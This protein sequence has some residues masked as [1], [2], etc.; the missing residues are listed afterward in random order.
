MLP[1]HLIPLGKLIVESKQQIRMNDIV[2]QFQ[3]RKYDHLEC[4]V[5][6][7]PTSVE[8]IALTPCAHKF[9]AEC[10]INV[11][12]CASA[13]REASGFCPE[14]REAFTRSELTLLGDAKEIK[15]QCS[16]LI[17]KDEEISSKKEVI[18]VS[19]E[20][21]GFRLTA[22]DIFSTTTD[23]NARRINY[24]T[25]SNKK[26]IEQQSRYPTIPLD[27]LNSFLDASSRVG[28]KI[29]RLLE[30][31]NIM[32]RKGVK[33]KCVVF[34]QFLDSLSI[35]SQEME[36]RGIRFVKVDGTMKQHQRADALFDFSSD[37]NIRVFLLSMR[38]GAAGLNLMAADHCFILDAPMNSAIEEQ[39]I[40]RIHRI[41]QTRPVV[42]KRFIIKNSVEER[43]LTCRRNL[44]ADHL[45]GTLIDGTGIMP[46]EQ[47][48]LECP[49]PKRT[50]HGDRSLQRLHFIE[51]LFGY[52]SKSRITL[53]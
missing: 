41:G 33:T 24:R 20:V 21:N 8:D 15:E 46:D 35:A 31:V 11:L 17:K 45:Q 5:C 26:K 14:C 3:E 39:A 19:T 34:S 32:M 2:L 16:N 51:A 52:S 23:S 9:C 27:F 47:T 25:L 38:A 28:T 36:A 42:V 40:D 13:T 12:D 30:E 44:A 4:A 22:K 1:C 53:T 29:S 10:V 43:I 6:L 50:Q 49:P 7:E 18:V 48:V 37:P